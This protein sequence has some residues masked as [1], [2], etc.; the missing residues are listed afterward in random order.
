MKEY[1]KKS[2]FGAKLCSDIC[3]W[4]LSVPRS[5]QLE[6][7]CS[8]LGTGN[9]RGKIS[10]HIFALNRGYRV[11]YPSNLFRNACRFENWGI[12]NNYSMS[13]RWI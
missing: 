11:Y 2:P 3:P 10:E 8:L 1:M 7:N 9:V 6:E 12:F 4:T 5:S 13:A